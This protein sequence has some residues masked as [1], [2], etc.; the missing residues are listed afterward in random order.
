MYCAV[1]QGLIRQV[2]RYFSFLGHKIEQKE[3]YW[4]IACVPFQQMSIN[5]QQQLIYTQPH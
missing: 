1:H 2:F 5:R 3:H 4:I